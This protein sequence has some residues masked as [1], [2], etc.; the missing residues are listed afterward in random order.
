VNDLAQLQK[1]A[2]KI[3]TEFRHAKKQYKLEKIELKRSNKNLKAASKA[4]SVL[5]HIAQQTQE[6]AHARISSIVT[7]CLEAVFESES[8]SFAFEFNRKRGRTEAVPVLRRNGKILRNPLNSAGGGPCQVAGFA[9]RVAYITLAE[10]QKRRLL[11]LDE[12]FSALRSPA[13]ER[14]EGMLIGLSRELGFQFILV[15]SKGSLDSLKQTGKV[16][17]IGD[18]K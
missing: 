13:S 15:P 8:Y 2:S 1:K 17:R 12:P 11:V 18:Q 10:P 4:Q 9:L 5:Q 14:L 6:I 16:I 3:L 7:K